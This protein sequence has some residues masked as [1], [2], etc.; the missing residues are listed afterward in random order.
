MGEK[1]ASQIGKVLY[2]LRLEK[3]IGQEELCYGLCSD[4]ALSRYELGER[5][6]DRLL[7]IA[8]L[9]RLGKS[10]DMIA[11]MLDAKEYT[12]FAWRKQVLE[13]AGREDAATLK[14]LLSQPEAED[15][16]C[17]EILQKQFLCRMRSVAAEAEGAYHD[18][19]RWL[20]EAI[21]LT[22][23]EPESGMLGGCLLSIEEIKLLIKLAELQIV[24]CKKDAARNLL[25]GI[26]AYS[27][28]QY[29]DADALLLVYPKAVRVLAPLLMERGEYAECF[30]LC[31]KAIEFLCRKGTLMDLTVLLRL[32][33]EC[34]KRGVYAENAKLY[35]KALEGLEAVY[36]SYGYVTDVT[37]QQSE[38]YF[39]QDIYLVGEVLKQYRIEKAISQEELSEGICAPETISRIESGK[40]APNVKNYYAL[41]QKL[42][43]EVEYFDAGIDTADFS[44]IILKRELSVAIGLLQWEKAEE[45]LGQLK[46]GL[47]REGK[48]QSPRN[49]MALKPEEYCI[50]YNMKKCSTE[51]FIAVCEQLADCEHER[52][53]EETYWKQFLTKEKIRILNYIAVLYAK[54][55]EFD[56]AV[57]ILEGVLGWLENSSVMLTER[58]SESRIAMANLTN[59][60]NSM[61]LLEKCLQMS[62][63]CI[64]FCLYSG[65]GTAIPKLMGNQVE[66]LMVTGGNVEECKLHLQRAYYISK[67][68]KNKVNKSINE[69][70]V[71]HFGESIESKN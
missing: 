61:G 44:L 63:R 20:G 46:S 66:V 9:Q 71:G 2:N 69:H 26:L 33:L 70:Y 6:P 37:E 64:R 21:R 38:Y 55:M 28:R 22:V 32:Y 25:R 15:L 1:L 48:L 41:A 50:R 60:Y 53:K 7:L 45:I 13:A 54:K 67:L 40:R 29:D 62:E 10:A 11:T 5:M 12:Y 14:E 56:K 65:H 58:A 8:L 36:Q 68:F 19:L 34:S 27:E 18:A 3:N 52:W 47:E 4:A 51:E 30:V 17:N 59:I 23:P 35:E 49:Q 39:N 16:S 31:Q 57:T 42:D 43:A 24:V